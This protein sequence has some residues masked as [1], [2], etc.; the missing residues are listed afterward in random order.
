[1]LFRS[2]EFILLILF[3]LALVFFAKGVG[4][5]SLLSFFITILA[6]W[7]ILV[8]SCLAGRDPIISG[9]IIVVILTF[10]IISMVY[11]YDKRCLAAS[12][13][14]LMGIGTTCLLS[15][16]FTQ[17]FN[18]HGAVMPYSESLLYAG[19]QHLNLTKI[20]MASVFLGASGA[21]MDIAVDITSAVHELV[22]NKPE[23]TPKAPIKSG[24]KVGRAVMGTMSTT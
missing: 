1:M 17:Q 2:Q 22:E 4:V 11:G 20:F 12:A 3:A 19:Y 5:R 15:I 18:I 16:I 14:V 8:P 23:I 9:L 21:L 10:V 13:G 24:L 7:K 6:I